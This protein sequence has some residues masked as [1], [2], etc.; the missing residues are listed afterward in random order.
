MENLAP[1]C[2]MSPTH[3]RRTFHSIMGYGALTYLNRTRIARA[4]VLLRT[5]EVGFHSVSS[6]NRH[7]LDIEGV[8]PLQYRKEMSFIRNKS[9]LK[10]TGWMTPPKDF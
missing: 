2:H 10:C 6:F 3:F 5:E 7:F 4:T 9:I 1:L 8:T